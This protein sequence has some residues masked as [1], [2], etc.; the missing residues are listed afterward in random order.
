MT[1]DLG[2]WQ[3]ERGKPGGWDVEARAYL[4]KSTLV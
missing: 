3:L 1:W 2:G 4:K